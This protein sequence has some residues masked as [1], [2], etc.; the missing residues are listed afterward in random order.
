[1]LLDQEGGGRRGSHETGQH[2]IRTMN[3]SLFCVGGD[4]AGNSYLMKS[5]P[6]GHPA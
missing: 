2:R 4:Q 6:S 5:L 3:A 1:M